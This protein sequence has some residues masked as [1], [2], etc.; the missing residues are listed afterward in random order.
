MQ[1]ED[2]IS[3]ISKKKIF[4]LFNKSINLEE[5]IVTCIQVWI[6]INFFQILVLAADFDIHH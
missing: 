4:G 6:R 5:I 3:E 1:K 2:E